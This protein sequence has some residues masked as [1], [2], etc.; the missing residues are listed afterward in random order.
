MLYV[1]IALFILGSVFL[2]NKKRI[3]PAD[4]GTDR[5]LGG[6]FLE[7]QVSFYERLDAGERNLFRNKIK[8]FL[9]DVVIT[10]VDTTVS[11]EDKLLVAAGAIIPIFYF[12][13]WKYYNLKEVLLYS[14]AIN[15]DFQSSEGTERDI[16]GMVGS[17]YMEGKM[18]LSKPALIAGFSNKTDKRNTVIH[19]FV[20]LI[21]KLDG[22]TDGV[23][24][25]LMQQQYLL[26]WLDMIR[27]EME[28]IR[29][30]D[31]DIDVY[32]YTNKTEFF[33]VAAEYFF[34]RP[35]LFKTKHPVLFQKMQAMFAVEKHPA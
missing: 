12:G 13:D 17:G 29:T 28:K 15:R 32:G 20:H 14:N 11:A 34:E 18:L 3:I 6:Q 30:G 27:Q 31:S 8:T 16:L 9:S 35:D 33:A 4:T 23:P 2:F 19:E 25:L 21:D 22:D 5:L 1:L 10:G 26:P 7:E 24:A